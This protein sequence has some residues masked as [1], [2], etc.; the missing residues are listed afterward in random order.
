MIPEFAMVIIK[1]LTTRPS[2]QP[3]PCTAKKAGVWLQWHDGVQDQ[4]CWR[5]GDIEILDVIEDDHICWKPW[6]RRESC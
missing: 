2:K 3:T 5:E 1:K 6:W 4:G